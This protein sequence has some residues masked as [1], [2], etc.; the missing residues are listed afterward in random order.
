MIIIHHKGDEAEKMEP[1][2]FEF[3]GVLDVIKLVQESDDNA[4]LI[5]EFMQSGHPN[6]K[7]SKYKPGMVQ[8]ISERIIAIFLPSKTMNPT[9]QR[10]LFS[11]EEIDEYKA[12]FS[13][14]E[15]KDE[16][17]HFTTFE[18]L[19]QSYQIE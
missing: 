6:G 8:S 4:T 10:K 13:L 15:Y 11:D 14:L 7:K 18:E 3:V 1:L 17:K 12:I 5:F 16:W 9:S 2:N 19:K